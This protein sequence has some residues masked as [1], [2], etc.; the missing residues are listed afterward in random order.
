MYELRDKLLHQKEGRNPSD[1]VPSA[2][3]A[4]NNKPNTC[5]AYLSCRIQVGT[6]R[7]Y[8]KCVTKRFQQ[9]L[10]GPR[11]LVP[12]ATQEAAVRNDYR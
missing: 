2:Q 3:E 10:N 5:T 1:K 4:D 6:R 8:L 9:C 7:F 12:V 11:T